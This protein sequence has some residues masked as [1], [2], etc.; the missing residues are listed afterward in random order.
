MESIVIKDITSCDLCDCVKGHDISL[1]VGTYTSTG[2]D[3]LYC[4]RWT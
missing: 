2:G 4:L 3:N 1:R